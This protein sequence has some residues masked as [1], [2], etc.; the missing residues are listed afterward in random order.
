MIDDSGRPRTSS[1]LGSHAL[2]STKVMARCL[3]LQIVAPAKATRNLH[4]HTDG[5]K[6]E[7]VCRR[8][9]AS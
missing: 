9:Y 6:E 2:L 4:C 8:F 3:L 5:G 1:Q 7:R